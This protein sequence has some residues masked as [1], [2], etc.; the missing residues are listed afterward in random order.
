MVAPEKPYINYMLI[1]Y[2]LFTKAR[3]NSPE[4]SENVIMTIEKALW[5]EMTKHVLKLQ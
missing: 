3:L 2:N 1:K 4:G 5:A